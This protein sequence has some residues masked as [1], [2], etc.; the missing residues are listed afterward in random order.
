MKGTNI[1]K[2]EGLLFRL[3][4]LATLFPFLSPVPIGSDTQPIAALLS[5]LII[6]RQLH[7]G[8]K[9]EYLVLFLIL[10]G[11]CL[12][13]DTDFEIEKPHVFK[14]I[15]FISGGLTYIAFSIGQKEIPVRYVKNAII[16]YCLGG[17]SWYI[18]PAITY[19]LQSYIV[20][21][22][23]TNIQT[24]GQYRG[25]PILSSEHGLAGA[26]L[27]GFWYLLDRE[28]V[29]RNVK[30]PMIYYAL[31][32]FAILLTKSGYGFFLLISYLIISKIQ[33]NKY[34]AIIKT[35]IIFLSLL[36]TIYL[37]QLTGID[38]GRGGKLVGLIF[39][40]DFFE[41]LLKD[42]SILKRLG[43]SF[44]IL[45]G[46]QSSAFGYGLN[47]YV[48]GAIE[49]LNQN[50]FLHIFYKDIDVFGF[51]SGLSWLMVSHGPLIF[52]GFIIYYF[53]KSHW[54]L[55]SIFLVFTYS[56][57]SFSLAFPITWYIIFVAKKEI[58]KH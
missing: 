17:I 19:D 4:F 48:N 28:R 24:V 56:V 3:L 47:N 14:Q 27:V 51:T 5:I 22:I 16:I 33:G 9:K 40:G 2:S 50:S 52:I 35:F 6:I 12:N 31:L 10:L 57:F 29:S 53:R 1:N 44:I 20:R 39:S 25:A 15:A 49:I 21:A 7:K 41:H 58:K 34:L 26:L 55:S 11:T 18:A 45:Y 46:I 13:I 43:D 8:I 37:L 32:F 54:T 38:L 36:I 42:F 23:N 30:I